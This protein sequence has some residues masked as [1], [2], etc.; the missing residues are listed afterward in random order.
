MNFNIPTQYY[1]YRTY[2]MRHGEE[3]NYIDMLQTWLKA[4][5]NRGYN[6]KVLGPFKTI[7]GQENEVSYFFIWD[8]LAQMEREWVEIYKDKELLEVGLPWW[9]A[10]ERKGPKMVQV[11]SE[12]LRAITD[13]NDVVYRKDQIYEYRV[14]N[15][16]T[17]EAHRLRTDGM[18][19]FFAFTEKHGFTKVGPFVPKF[20][21]ENDFSYL[22]VWDSLLERERAMESLAGDPDLDASSWYE[23]E[24]EEGPLRRSCI[25]KLMKAV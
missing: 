17:S 12:L 24:Q 7:L 15:F 14:Y 22:F 11:N 5:Q 19:N 21:C 16:K 13:N 1:E 23:R 4:A 2:L 9:E 20:G 10:E 3:K 25:S 18:A 8:S 6:F